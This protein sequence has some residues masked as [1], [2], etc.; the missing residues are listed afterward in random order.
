MTSTT[1]NENLAARHARRARGFALLFGYADRHRKQ[2]A[3]SRPKL[4]PG[5]AITFAILAAVS[6]LV[7]VETAFT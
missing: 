4:H 7:F 1:S 2:A 5:A 3:A 6:M